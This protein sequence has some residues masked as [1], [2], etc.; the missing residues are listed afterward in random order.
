MRRTDITLLLGLLTAIAVSSFTGLAAECEEVRGEVLRLHIIPNSDSAADQML[1]YAIR[2]RILIDAADIFAGQDSTGAK[3]LAAQRL[4]ELERIAD[5]VIA[6]HG[7]TYKSS[8]VIVNMY[9]ATREYDGG[10]AAPAGRYDAVRI[11]IGEGGGQNWWCIMFPPMCL[12]A[13]AGEPAERIEDKLEEIGE[14]RYTPKFAVV[15]WV[16]SVRNR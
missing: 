8:A 7:Y 9:F 4:G 11:I 3:E 12:P 16:E 2:D 1:K 10:L 5:E 15:E 14:L 6:E 13:A